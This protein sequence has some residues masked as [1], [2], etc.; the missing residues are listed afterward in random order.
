MATN[1]NSR[2]VPTYQAPSDGTSTPSSGDSPRASTGA[3]RAAALASLYSATACTK[4]YPISG[5]KSSSIVHKALPLRISH[6]SFTSS[7][8]RGACRTTD[9]SGKRKEDLL[10]TA[11]GEMRARAELAERADTADPAVR[12]QDKAVAHPFGIQ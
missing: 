11:G 10:Q 1:G 8:R 7:G 3:C 4:L 2:V 9:I 5:H 6:S 12:E